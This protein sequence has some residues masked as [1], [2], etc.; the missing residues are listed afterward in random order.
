MA[1]ILLEGLDRVGKSSVAEMYKKQGFDVVHMSAP[2]KKYFQPGYSGPS[3]LEEIVDMYNIYSGKNVLFDRT[4]YG[5]C[6]WPEIYNRQA[7]LT[8]EDFEYLQRLEYNNDAVRILMYDENTEAHWQR[9]VE[10]NEPLNR[11]QF[12]QAGRLYDDLAKRYNFEKHQLNDFKEGVEQSRNE[13]K[14]GGNDGMPGTIQREEGAGT[15]AASRSANSSSTTLEEKLE[16][17][18]AIRSLLD[19]SLVK[20]KGDVFRKLEE[21]IK[22]FLENELEN[23]FSEP[24]HND[25]T[26]EEVQILKIYAQRIKEKLG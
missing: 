18:N 24:K 1:W 14:N 12:V 15:H 17:A 13:A 2:D 6:V 9:C 4:I 23:I 21:D 3:Y 7:L 10:N 11:L 16:R 25:F 5:E 20:K 19:T 26:Q 22:V 8:Q